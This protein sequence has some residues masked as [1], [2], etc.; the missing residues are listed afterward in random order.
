MHHWNKF[1]LTGNFKGT[2][3]DF[4][5]LID[6]RT[7]GFKGTAK[8][9][10]IPCALADSTDCSRISGEFN[11]PSLNFAKLSGTEVL[12]GG[13]ISGTYDGILAEGRTAL[14]VNGKLNTIQI[15]KG[16]LKNTDLFLTM[17]DEKINVLSSFDNDSIRGA[18]MLTCDVG[19]EVF[20]LSSKGKIEVNDLADFGWGITGGKEAVKTGFDFVYAKKKGGDSFGNYAFRNFTYAGKKA[21]FADFRKDLRLWINIAFRYRS[22][23]RKWKFPY[24]KRLSPLPVHSTPYLQAQSLQAEY[25]LP[26][27]ICSCR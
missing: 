12:G 2:I 5:L 23:N 19:K 6:S 3:D 10:Y 20:F 9:G 27:C 13:H 14:N 21:F 8:L 11:F 24:P 22:R 17:D 4:I 16:K 26:S 1:D 18:V 25:E 15:G 7:T